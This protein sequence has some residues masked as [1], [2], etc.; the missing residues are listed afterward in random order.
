MKTITKLSAAMIATGLLF[1]CTDSVRSNTA[2]SETNNAVQAGEV[3]A[4]AHSQ[5]NSQEK[6]SI[7]FE[8]YTLA[9]GLKVILH[10]DKSDPIVAMATIAHV[11]SNREKPGRTGFAHFFEHMSF[12]DSE[13]VPKGANRKMIPELGGTRNGGT[14]NDGTIYYEVVPKDAFAKLMWI[15]S[16]R[17]GFMINT[18]DQGTLE[19]EKQVV[20]NEKRQRVDNRAY[21]HT[22]HVI[23]K[24][25][26]P[27]EHPYNWTVIG[28]LQDLQNATLDDVREFYNTFYVPSNAT[29][30]IAGDIDFT[31]TKVMVENWFGE[32][33]KGQPLEPIKAMPITLAES[34]YLY[35]ED[36]LAK[37]PE[38][39]ITLP[40]VEQYHPD[41]WALTALAEILSEGKEAPLF[42]TLVKKDKLAPSVS[43]NQSSDEIAGTFTFRVRAN[44]GISLGKIESAIAKALKSFEEN[45][46]SDN[47]LTKIKAR[48]ETDF[49]NNIS[50]VLDK[51]FQ[52]GIYNEYAGDP[53]YISTDIEE[54]SKVSRADIMRVYHTYIK[55]KPAVVTSFVPKGQRNLIVTGSKKANVVEEEIVAG[56]EKEFTENEG[57]YVKTKTVFD[58]SEPPLSEAP[59]VKMPDVWQSKLDNGMEVY[60]IEHS[61]LP[62][63]EFSL[64]IDGGQWLDK[65]NKLGNASLMA[66]LMNEGTT[67]KTAAQLEEAIGLLGAS[68]TVSSRLDAVYVSGNTLTKNFD[69][70]I[71]LMTEILLEPRF[72][73]Q[74][75]ERLKNRQLTRIKSTL[76]NPAR[77]ARQ[78]FYRQVYGQNHLAGNPLGGIEDTVKNIKLA[79]VKTWYKS[80]ISPQ[81]ASL[82]VVGDVKPNQ[83]SRALAKLNSGWQGKKVN[84]PKLDVP[85]IND[86]VKIYFIDIEGAKQSVIYAGKPALTG[87]DKDYYPLTV[88]N[89]RLGNGSSARLTQKLRIEKGYTYGAYSYIPRTSFVAPFIASSQ[90]RSNVTLESLELFKDLIGNYNATFD[91]SH[92]AVT[93][94]LISKGNSRQFETLTQLRRTLETL[95]AHNLSMDYIDQQQSKLKAMSLDD[96][97]ALVSKYIN[98]QQFT[99]VIA[100]DAKTQLAKV[101]AFGYG[102]PIMLNRNGEKL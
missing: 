51:A 46:F 25:L 101:K 55:N 59:V 78:A 31:E 98:E 95:S 65:A 84:L 81:N 97:H 35:H 39:R 30:V 99:Y 28:D 47:Q 76:G 60:G 48:Q 74:D 86:K 17:L 36:N 5:D 37:L 58:R 27:E 10:Q 54:I 82:H 66:A 83:V 23:R 56:A 89:N 7:P 14:W 57:G 24:A 91:E 43:A 77:I 29:L 38:L 8:Q 18:V 21:G 6:F 63:V 20:K 71:E 1:S 45:G 72:E 52:L 90:V 49:Y 62:L 85:K 3:Q 11:G 75:F 12:N 53:N 73:Q 4:I 15:D 33:K 19:R 32:I 2:T 93:K 61:E 88:A 87:A 50:S 13:N 100:G 96:L 34:K 41:S 40:T 68:L 9:N 80:N 70:T 67:N 42:S 22:G 16:D 92:L 64:R 79:D 94:N 26:Y 102:E 69:A 44:A